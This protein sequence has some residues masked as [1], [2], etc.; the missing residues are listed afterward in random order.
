MIH[1]L[2]FNFSIFFSQLEEGESRKVG[3]REKRKKERKKE[4]G[5]CFSCKG[6]FLYLCFRK[7]KRGQELQPDN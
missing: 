7:A 3:E 1:T 4:K 5:Q 2:H 6:Q